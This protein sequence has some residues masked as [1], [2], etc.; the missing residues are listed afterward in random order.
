MR[1]RKQ[2]RDVQAYRWFNADHA[3]HPVEITGPDSTLP[4]GVLEAEWDRG[5]RAWCCRLKTAYG[6]ITLMDGDWILHDP[7]S[8]DVWPVKDEFFRATY[9]E[10]GEDNTADLAFATTGEL[11]NALRERNQTVCVMRLDHEGHLQFDIAGNMLTV[12]GMVGRLSWCINTGQI[13]P[14]D[15]AQQKGG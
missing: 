10:V 8:G 14:T 4:K 9:R 1:V 2:P 6:W 5:K 12:L 3:E 15:P 11:F 13:V 7:A